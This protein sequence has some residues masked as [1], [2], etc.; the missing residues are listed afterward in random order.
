MSELKFGTSGLRG[1]ISDFT[2]DACRRYTFAFLTFLRLKHD[3]TKGQKIWVGRDLRPSSVKIAD[4]V[5]Q[6][7]LDFG[8]NVVNCGPLP[9]PALAFAAQCNRAPAIMVTGSNI[10]E[11]RNGLKFFRVA[12]EIDKH[13]E[14]E[15]SNQLTR[16]KKLLPSP[17]RIPAVEAAAIKPYFNRCMTLLAPNALRGLRIGIYQHSSVARDLLVDVIRGLGS[18]VIPINR[19][20]N[21]IA[22]DTE[23]IKPRDHE[24]VVNACRKYKLDAIVSTDGDGDRPLITD[25]DGRFIKGDIIGIFA[26]KY[27]GAKTVVTPLTSTALVE[28]TGFFDH[29]YRCRVGS[30]FVIAAMNEMIANRAQNVVGFEANGGVI[31]GSDLSINERAIAPLFTR[32][33]LL[34]ILCVL[35]TVQR[36]QQSLAALCGELPKIFTDSGRLEN[37]PTIKSVGA[38]H[39][40][41][42]TSRQSAFFAPIGKVKSLNTFDGVKVTLEN[43][44]VIH[45]RVSGNAPELRCYSQAN[46][47]EKAQ[48]L[49]AW[50]LDSIKKLLEVEKK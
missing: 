47:I 11:D 43:D 32:D 15:I 14:L 30:P 29:V 9:T 5:M 37:V 6:A 7:A 42:E 38:L 25:A 13:D 2:F 18:D 19:C 26:A 41:E 39:A 28:L 36:R 35:G 24:I 27:L 3:L 10:A 33:A 46:S 44:E 23:A 17:R 48:K 31:V 22:I 21:F 45:F 49:V 12:S 4:Y 40:L 20:E 50:G 34:P 1:L 16:Q 8:Y